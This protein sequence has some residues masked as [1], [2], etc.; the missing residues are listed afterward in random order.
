MTGFR[1]KS[2][3]AALAS[4]LLATRV[5]ASTIVVDSTADENLDTPAN[6]SCTLREAVLASNLDSPVDGCVAGQSF[7]LVDRI[8]LGAATYLLILEGVTEDAG[9]TGD[10]DILGSVEIVGVGPDQTIIDAGGPSGMK[11][12][13][14]HVHTD[15]ALELAELALTGGSLQPVLERDALGDVIGCLAQCGEGFGGALL[16]EN[17]AALLTNARIESNTLGDGDWSW[18]LQRVSGAGVAVLN[19]LVHA[20]DSSFIGNEAQYLADGPG[21]GGARGGALYLDAQSDVIIRRSDFRDN[22]AYQWYE[23]VDGAISS[24]RG[25]AIDAEGSIRLVDSYF[26]GNV[27]GRDYVIATHAGLIMERCTVEQNAGSGTIESGIRQTGPGGL[28]VVLGPA[29]V[30]NS[31]FSANANGQDTLAGAGR[32]GAISAETGEPVVVRSST[33]VGGPERENALCGAPLIVS[34]SIISQSECDSPTTS[35]SGGGNV[36]SDAS[37]CM[38]AGP[39]DLEV[40]DVMLGPLDDSLGLTPVYRPLSGSPV[41]DAA[42]ADATLDHDQLGQP[43]PVDR[44][45]DGTAAF[46]VGAIELQCTTDADDDGVDDCSDNCPDLPNPDQSDL[47]ADGIG[48]ACDTTGCGALG[49]APDGAMATPLWVLLAGLLVARLLRARGAAHASRQFRQSRA[50]LSCSAGS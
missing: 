27:A 29:S 24:G 43:R 45:G 10:L 21:G 16:V 6:G 2:G 7:P 48:D 44:D 1:S 46:D 41:V 38:T 49:N 4:M 34:N 32:C 30:T 9:A 36:L 19:S 28:G 26:V 20:N 47:D 14:F 35:Q 11:D 33:F 22:R 12:R 3:M 23:T 31:T 13:L 8:E 40:N 17:S 37:G 50:S 15:A 42:L 18:T 39:Q 25:S 5:I